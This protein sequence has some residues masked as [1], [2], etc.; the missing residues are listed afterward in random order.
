VASLA[1]VVAVGLPSAEAAT[2]AVRAGIGG[3][4]NGTLAG[5]DG[6]GSGRITLN[7]TGLRLVKQARRLD[8]TVL[9]QGAT[10]DAG[11]ELV[12]VLLVENPTDVPAEDVRLVDALDET[13]FAYVAGTLETAEVASG[14][15]DAAIWTAAW[16]VLTDA[17]GSPDDEASVLDTGGPSGADRIVVG[18]ES[19]QASRPV[20]VPAGAVRAVRFRVRVI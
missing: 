8:G 3:L 11:Q 10:V 9:P 4:D 2:N 17:L 6:T 18:A 1:L 12:F 5:G 15:D 14:A 19:G 13:A 7:A 20:D 16:S